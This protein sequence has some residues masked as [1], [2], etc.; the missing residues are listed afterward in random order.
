MNSDYARE[1]TKTCGI[2]TIGVFKCPYHPTCRV[3]TFS[4][5]TVGCCI[6]EEFACY[7]IKFAYFSSKQTDFS[8]IQDDNMQNPKV[9]T[10]NRQDFR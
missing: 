2:G 8:S 1:R 7:T 4:L 6:I 10:E 3:L 9:L 5:P